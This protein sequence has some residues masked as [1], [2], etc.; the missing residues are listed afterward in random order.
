[1]HREKMTSGKREVRFQDFYWLCFLSLPPGLHKPLDRSCIFTCSRQA[2]QE[3]PCCPKEL[4]SQSWSQ[5]WGN[6]QGSQTSG[7][8][9]AGER[10]TIT[11]SSFSLCPLSAWPWKQ[12]QPQEVN[13]RLGREKPQLAKLPSQRTRKGGG[14]GSES[15]EAMFGG[16]DKRK[17]L[18]KRT[19]DHRDSHPSC[20][21]LTRAPEGAPT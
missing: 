4:G 14:G 6:L 13:G 21:H 19:L 3:S 2:T 10:M 9:W 17:P 11:A 20:A 16:M 1:M 7:V 15:W 5:T 12:T 18:E 8:R